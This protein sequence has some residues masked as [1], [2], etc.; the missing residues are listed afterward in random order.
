MCDAV[1]EFVGVGVSVLVGVGVAVA[2]AVGVILG[3]GVSVAVGVN[4][5]VGNTFDSAGRER[6]QAGSLNTRSNPKFCA[7]SAGG[8]SFPRSPSN[9]PSQ[10]TQIVLASEP[11][12]TAS[13]RPG[14]AVDGDV[15]SLALR[16]VTPF[17][18][19]KSI[20]SD[21]PYKLLA[22]SSGLQSTV[23]DSSSRPG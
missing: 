4:V 3:V 6:L 7:E 21:H 22:A 5:G 16:T 14:P 23:M 11:I 17:Q 9:P 8:S 12:F 15:L 18:R 10:S 2:V 20:Y 1:G 19:I 13:P